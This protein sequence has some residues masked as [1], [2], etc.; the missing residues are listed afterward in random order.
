M[1]I[2]FKGGCPMVVDPQK[3]HLGGNMRGG[4][5]S[6]DFSKCLWP[7][8]VKR[9]AI[10]SLLD[11]GCAEGHALRAFSALG[12]PSV[13]GLEGLWQNARRCG[14]PT[15]AHD[16]TTG[17]LRIEGID[18]VWC[19]DTVEHVEEKY[20]QNILDTF[21]CAKTVALIHG[22]ETTANNG[23]HHCNNRPAA[24]WDEKMVGAGFE[25]DHAGTAEGKT[26]S[27]LGLWPQA[28]RIFTN[29]KWPR[30]WPAL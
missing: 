16:L 9:Y 29:K 12:V 13:L 25:I 1:V 18:F 5:V 11:V 27:T 26:V 19:C 3:P 23:W 22:D 30:E 2:D 6:T 8:L 20:A 4:D 14:V 21:A 7:W 17:P 24:Y 15:I 10:K 28:G